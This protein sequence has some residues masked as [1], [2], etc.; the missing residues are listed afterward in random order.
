MSTANSGRRLPPFAKRLLGC[1]PDQPGSLRVY[2]GADAWRVGGSWAR[3]GFPVVVL[4]PDSK[5]EDFC[6]SWVKGWSVLVVDIN[7]TAW[8]SA[9]RR[10]GVL[11]VQSGAVLVVVVTSQPGAERGLVY[12]P[13][14]YRG[15]A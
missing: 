6:W 8:L 11:L 7:N 10:L 13:I 2:C 15:A 5:P 1:K 12:K 14:P 3:A 9:L 4:P